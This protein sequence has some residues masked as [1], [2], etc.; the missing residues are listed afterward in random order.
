MRARLTVAT[1]STLF[2]AAS[3]A[4]GVSRLYSYS[5]SDFSVNDSTGRY[6]DACDR[7]N[8]GHNVRGDWVRTGGVSGSITEN[9]GS[10]ECARAALSTVV[11]R[12]R[13]VEIVPVTSD[14][15]GPWK[16]PT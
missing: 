15:E 16:Y 4:F 1:V 10:G 9:G 11:Y 8:D 12:H 3:P 7:E 13:I 5:G 14:E 2:L 6:I